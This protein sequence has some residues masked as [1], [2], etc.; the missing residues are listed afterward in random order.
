[1]RSLRV[2]NFEAIVD[3]DLY[4]A[5]SR[6]EWFV[7]MKG[8]RP[9][10]ARDR[11]IYLHREVARMRGLPVAGRMID[12]VNGNTLDNQSVNLR[13]CSNAQNQHN[14][15]LRARPKSSPYK[16]VSWHGPRHYWQ[17]KIVKDGVTRWLGRFATPELAASAYDAA[18]TQL[19]GEFAKTNKMLGLLDD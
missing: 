15:R 16:G 19:Y 10:I 17:A 12:H 9:Y 11:N 18:A 5:L 14:Q 7:S 6:H 8:D 2:K 3:D 13:S 1:M 4:A